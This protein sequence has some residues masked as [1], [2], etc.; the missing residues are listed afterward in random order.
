[1]KRTIACALLSIS[2]ALNLLAPAFA[3]APETNVLYSSINEPVQYSDSQEERTIHIV[4]DGK[5]HAPLGVKSVLVDGTTFVP[6]R[7][8]GEKLG[9]SVSWNET[10]NTADINNGAI[11][12]VLGA[13]TITRYGQVSYPCSHPSFLYEGSFM[14]GLRQVASALNY[15]V[16]WDQA[17]LT[18]YLSKRAQ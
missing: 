3:D 7:V 12:A 18:A 6:L 9:Y 5:E 1:V 15:K 2:L 11:M 8:M 17:T 16:D 13:Y 10:N 4:I 14:V